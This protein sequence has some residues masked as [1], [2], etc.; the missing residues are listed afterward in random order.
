MMLWKTAWQFLKRNCGVTIGPGNSTL[1]FGKPLDR[2]GLKF[3]LSGCQWALMSHRRLRCGAAFRNVELARRACGCATHKQPIVL[4]PS[5]AK[6]QA[7][8]RAC[9]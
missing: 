1:R 7:C 2:N 3:V 9:V 8:A 4:D 6:T 5:V